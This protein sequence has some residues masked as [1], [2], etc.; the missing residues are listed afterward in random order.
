MASGGD[1]KIAIGVQDLTRSGIARIVNELRKIPGGLDIAIRAVSDLKAIQAARNE[2]G[3]AAN[4][5]N[6][7]DSALSKRIGK[8]WLTGA[9]ADAKR[10]E[11]NLERIQNTLKG[12][13]S[14][15]NISQALLGGY[16]KKSLQERR[17]FVD[18]VINE[19]TRLQRELNLKNAAR[20][21]IDPNDTQAVKAHEAAVSSLVEKL[22]I[23]GTIRKSA[24]RIDK[25]IAKEESRI[26]KQQQK[27]E[28]AVRKQR[29]RDIKE[30]FANRDRENKLNS[31][32]K[33]D[34]ERR[35]N[36]V[37]ANA[38]R[39]AREEER[40]QNASRR[41][42]ERDIKHAFAERD[43]EQRVKRQM[44]QEERK[45][46]NARKREDEKQAR[47]SQRQQNASRRERERDIK[48]AFAERDAEQ[49]VKRQMLQEE[50]RQAE[51]TRRE[52]EKRARETERQQARAHRE[53]ERDI[54][55]AFV[56]DAKR[57]QSMR[58][59][60]SA[61]ARNSGAF[62]R[63]YFDDYL[64]S[65]KIMPSDKRVDEIVWKRGLRDDKAKELANAQSKLQ[66]VNPSDTQAIARQAQ[67]VAH[68]R[69]E[70]SAL[71]SELKRLRAAHVQL[72]DA[73]RRANTKAIQQ[74]LRAERQEA[75]R[76]QQEQK[77]AL[78]ESKQAAT[79]YRAELNNVQVAMRS[80]SQFAGQLREDIQQAFSYYALKQFLSNL[81]EIGGQFEY[82]RRA[83]A[84]ILQDTTKANT[85]FNQIKE[86]GLKSPFSTLELD[87]YAKQLSAFDIPYHKMY[88]TLK[89][90]ADIAA[91]TGADMSR[92]ILAYGHVKSEGFLTGIQRRQFSNA[93]INIVGG[94][95]DYY[96]KQEGQQ[97]TKRDV[98][99]RIHDKQVTF[100][101]MDTVLMSMAEEGGQFHNMQEV[102]ASTVKGTYKNLTDAINH[103]YMAIEKSANGPL[104]FFGKT[105]TS[106]I[107]LAESFPGAATRFVMA[108]TAMAGIRALNISR[109]GKEAEMTVKRIML[110]DK[111]RIAMDKNAAIYGK[112]SIFQGQGLTKKST[113]NLANLMRQNTLEGQAT[114]QAVLRG[115]AHRKINMETANQLVVLKAITQ[116]ELKAAAAARGMWATIKAG[117]IS[118][119]TTLKAG[120]TSLLA[121]VWP[122][123]AIWGAVEAGM[124]A[125]NKLMGTEGE[126]RKKA[127]IQ[128]LA[129]SYNSL[130]REMDGLPESFDNMYTD[131]VFQS[132]KDMVDVIK[133]ELV[134]AEII[135]GRVFEKDA[136]GG[137]LKNTYDQAVALRLELEEAARI[138]GILRDDDNISMYTE[139]KSGGFKDKYK[140]Y[141]DATKK[142]NEYLKIGSDD[143]YYHI[144]QFL[145]SNKGFQHLVEGIDEGNKT[146]RV[147][148]ILGNRKSIDA[149][150]NWLNPHDTG[151]A[152]VR[153]RLKN[154][155]YPVLDSYSEMSNYA[156]LN[157]QQ[158]SGIAEN[159]GFK[160]VREKYGVVMN[161]LG[162][163]DLTE[164]EKGFYAELITKKHYP[165]LYKGTSDGN[166]SVPNA[167]Y[168]AV[169]EK[170]GEN[171]KDNKRLRSFDIKETDTSV[172][173]LDSFQK[174]YKALWENFEGY[175][176]D[177]H[178]KDLI[179]LKK[180]AKIDLSKIKDPV[181][182]QNAENFNKDLERYG[183]LIDAAKIV[184]Y[185]EADLKKKK[186]GGSQKDQWLEDQQVWFD[187]LK[188]AAKL[189]KD[190]AKVFGTEEAFDKISS[191]PEFKDVLSGMSEETLAQ[192]AR[193]LEKYL[194]DNSENFTTDDRKKFRNRVAQ[195]QGEL[196][197]ADLKDNL[198]RSI[199]A[200]NKVFDEQLDSFDT[201]TKMY[202]ATGS[203]STASTL[204]FGLNGYKSFD[205]R[206]LGWQTSNFSDFLKNFT[207]GAK[208]FGIT[209][210]YE[211]YV[212]D[213]FNSQMVS[214][215]EAFT[216]DELTG[217]TEEDWKGKGEAIRDTFKKAEQS[218]KQW[219]KSMMDAYANLLSQDKSYTHQLEV[220]EAQLENDKNAVIAST[221]EGSAERNKGISLAEGKASLAK[222]NLKLEGTTFAKN[223]RAVS[224]PVFQAMVTDLKNLFEQAFSSGAIDRNTYN[225]RM[226]DIK[227]MEKEHGNANRLPFVSSG[228]Q[229]FLLGGF[230]GYYQHAKSN[231]DY[232]KANADMFSEEEIEEA[233][234]ELR[235]AEA[236]KN[237]NGAVKFFADV[238]T[239]GATNVKSALDLLANMFDALGMESDAAGVKSVSNVLG[240]AIGGAQSLSFLGPYG[241]AVGGVLGGITAIAQEH[242]N[243]LN[244]AIE[245]SKQR[246]KDIKQDYNEIG[247]EI[248]R[249][250]TIDEAGYNN[251]RSNLLKQ[252]EELNKQLDLEQ[253]KKKKD[254]DA[255][256]ELESQISELKDQIKYYWSDLLKELYGIDFKDYGKRL[257]DSLVSAFQNGEDAAIAW[258]KTVGDIVRDLANDLV[259]Q[260]F[261]MPMMENLFDEAFGVGGKLTGKSQ[262]SEDDVAWLGDRLDAI[263]SEVIPQAHA[264]YEALQMAFPYSS[265]SE[266]VGGLTRMGQQLT[267]ETGTILA[268]YINS[269][270]ADVSHNRKNLNEI[271]VRALPALDE[272]NTV[273]KAQLTQ[274]KSI[275]QNTKANA[276]A[277]QSILSV[278]QDATNGVRSFS[279][280]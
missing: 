60:D 47:E 85:L 173:M 87:S 271:V 233:E 141:K 162:S 32:I 240:G 189:Y 154:T 182:W 277:A 76:A 45:Q 224:K 185:D 56:A 10:Y 79:Q 54:N 39:V 181:A 8:N 172:Q 71:N 168:K 12:Q 125:W 19:Q 175:A 188:K 84:N 114:K 241:A 264:L 145:S 198:M 219:K 109:M 16:D 274:L 128:S 113:E 194:A 58:T 133:N 124:W 1:L 143:L 217:W 31:Q 11:Q 25:Q 66:A 220:I 231:V 21:T 105:L 183:N 27:E 101:D 147:R 178:L 13:S 169:M 93:N 88:D 68:L 110:L 253:K 184:G 268:G 146:G 121:S 64:R 61:Y 149:F 80:T 266:S 9:I 14:V 236:W 102:M 226:D 69:A 75:K 166:V 270:R 132:I 29:E 48:H 230:D 158:W 104:M 209:G 180:L 205:E 131:E 130:K 18:S 72:N 252:Q 265:D 53:R 95:A 263:G 62:Q 216:Y 174:D 257:S 57:Q 215:G 43:A 89:K 161:A 206:V 159:Q 17:N 167:T 200:V 108:A 245:K 117:A 221:A 34:E 83:I 251:S 152:K 261:I 37:R 238:L 199:N 97:V 176:E 118:V 193:T 86:L 163:L 23:L 134:D 20:R 203:H 239:K 250:I 4:A 213:A 115:I 242:D 28:A 111:E 179:N 73:E 155:F 82:Q 52:E 255:I 36:T 157:K 196:D 55:A 260:H 190:N 258:H 100:E 232:M 249:S 67:V 46:E 150:Y 259:A 204:A 38:E 77:K 160:W 262:I 137:Y 223:F 5:A 30:A 81:I 127:M 267:E 227:K 187:T 192:L 237:A 225:E 35:A 107:K 142:A 195:E 211:D 212:K 129:D 254:K 96:S 153:N 191:M 222:A 92:I 50:R 208:N 136:N 201:Y 202:N 273:A 165:A 138:K 177:M 42:R 214:L 99:K 247:R 65:F 269:I 126:E 15:K 7:L 116:E 26:L 243:R 164:E 123:L 33:R 94:L 51:A 244:A 276:D 3:K 119:F 256:R 49:R 40:K 272:V 229:A 106:I 122:M 2:M 151:D 44:L 112:N 275:E 98:Y 140:D 63:A 210:S 279:I 171:Y 120:I 70:Y 22:R 91:G 74:R 103:M 228:T 218:I 246:L 156:S 278:L 248:K 90:M 41:E 235:K 234:A 6:K 280:V 78:Q 139:V 135:L 207:I 170:L 24:D 197:L 148:A 186:K 144:N 59:I